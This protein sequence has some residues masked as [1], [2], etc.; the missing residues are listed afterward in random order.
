MLLHATPE[1]PTEKEIE[2][3]YHIKN[4]WPHRNRHNKKNLAR[5]EKF[6]FESI[7]HE[8]DLLDDEDMDWSIFTH[9]GSAVSKLNRKEQISLLKRLKKALVENNHSFND[10][11]LILEEALYR[12]VTNY[13]DWVVDNNDEYDEDSYYEKAYNKLLNIAKTKDHDDMLSYFKDEIWWDMDF[14]FWSLKP[15]HIKNYKK[16]L[17]QYI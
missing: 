17:K 3:C 6:V 16:I 7:D 8:L 5:F 12:V 2:F 11:D 14:T 13:V 1:K 10:D 15:S 4:R 9:K